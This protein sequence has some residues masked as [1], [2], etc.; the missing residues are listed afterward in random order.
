MPPPLAL[1]W[2]RSMPG[3]R[4]RLTASCAGA[5]RLDTQWR[6]A[7]ARGVAF[8]AVLH[9]EAGDHCCLLG[10]QHSIRAAP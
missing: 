4:P 9:S 1:Q 2:R 8:L 6:R 7:R 10:A 3:A 5:P